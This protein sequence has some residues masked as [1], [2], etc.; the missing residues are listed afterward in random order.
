MCFLCCVYATIKLTMG[1]II[2]YLANVET[3]HPRT[4]LEGLRNMTRNLS[5]DCKYPSMW[6]H[7]NIHNMPYVYKISPQ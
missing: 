3:N 7:C 5:Q 1:K 2:S 6:N 4:C